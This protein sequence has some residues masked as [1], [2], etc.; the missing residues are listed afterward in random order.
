MT[1]APERFR[2]VWPN[3]AGYVDYVR[4]DLVPQWRP[5]ET[6]PKDG[7]Y[8]D[9]WLVRDDPEDMAREP[10]CYWCDEIEEWCDRSGEFV[11]VNGWRASHWMPIPEGPK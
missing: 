6:A 8:V 11:E 10:E 7:Q 2:R 5:I 1:D 9:L 3:E 4:A